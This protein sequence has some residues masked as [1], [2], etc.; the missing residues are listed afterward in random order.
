MPN[1][2]NR[3][4]PYP[5]NTDPLA[6]AYAAIQAL[7]SALDVR[8]PACSVAK[9]AVQA[10]A[11]G[12]TTISFDT[13]VYDDDAMFIAP[14]AI[15]TIKTAGLYLVTAIG[16]FSSAAGSA[17]QV[18]IRKNGVDTAMAALP[19]AAISES[20]PVS[21]QGRCAVNDQITL[22]LFQNSGAA[23]NSLT[24]LEQRPQMQVT[25]VGP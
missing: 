13:E 20:V 23:I 21:W 12:V 6:N 10:L 2:P 14:N 8:R 17:R 22:A 25:W 18:I 16:G 7:A 15:V 1:T 11:S 9:A 24:A 4:L 5:A 3:V 19:G